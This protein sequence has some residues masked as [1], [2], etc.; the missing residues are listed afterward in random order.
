MTDMATDAIKT[1][2]L[3]FD[4]NLLSRLNDNIFQI[5][6]QNHVSYLQD[7]DNDPADGNTR[8]I[9]PDAEYEDMIQ[10]PKLDAGDT[11]YETFDQYIGAE[12]LVYNNGDPVPAKVI[13]RC[14]TLYRASISNSIQYTLL[15]VSNTTIVHWPCTVLGYTGRLVIQ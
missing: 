7:E 4:D 11:K 6:L 2:V 9:P 1:R 14:T 8:D 13:K 3:T 5:K 10:P 15:L 12:F